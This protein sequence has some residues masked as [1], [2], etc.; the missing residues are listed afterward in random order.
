MSGKKKHLM[1][2]EITRDGKKM[3]GTEHHIKTIDDLYQIANNRNIDKPQF[4]WKDD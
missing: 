2:L 3:D 4:R 1:T